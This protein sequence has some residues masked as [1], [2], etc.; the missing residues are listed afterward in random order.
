M[1]YISVFVLCLYLK[2]QNV[3]IWLLYSVR[4]PDQSFR[5]YCFST[6]FIVSYIMWKARSYCMVNIAKV[7]SFI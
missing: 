3:F 2:D 1:L 7:N 4:Y 6:D 5:Q